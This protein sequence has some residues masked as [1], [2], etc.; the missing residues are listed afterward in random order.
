M[1][2][3]YRHMNKKKEM[4]IYIEFYK[5]TRISTCTSTQINKYIQRKRERETERERA[6]QVYV[7]HCI[8]M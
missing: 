5:Y 7:I 6:I 3:I 8:V 4:S 1:K 2:R